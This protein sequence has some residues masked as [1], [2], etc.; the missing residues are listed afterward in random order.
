M[1]DIL[2]SFWPLVIIYILLLMMKFSDDVF[3]LP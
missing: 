2:V 1:L 3:C